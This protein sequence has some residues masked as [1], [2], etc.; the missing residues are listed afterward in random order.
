MSD[1][2]GSAEFELRAT[3]DKMK[4]DLQAAEKDLKQFGNKAEANIGGSAGRIG[5]GIGR[6]AAVAVAAITALV[7]VIG[8]AVVGAFNLGMAGQ[9]MASDIANS[10]KQIGV[11]TDALQEWRSVA[12]Q[13]G[14]A[15]EDADKA[16]SAF[17]KKF[18]EA[19]SGLSKESAKAFAAIG[20]S[21]EQLRSF[22][23]VEAALDATVDRIGDLG[24]AADRAAISERL[25]LGPLSD[26]L[27]RGADDIARMR[28]EAHALGV[29]MDRDMIQRATEAQKEF[30]TLSRIIGIQLQT[31]F[32][33][34]APVLNTAIGLIAEAARQ[35]GLFVD[36]FRELENR[37]TN[38]LQS[39]RARL[40]AERD[41]IAG[42]FGTQPLDGRTVVSA[43]LPGVEYDRANLSRQA[44]REAP[45]LPR[46][47]TRP[48]GNVFLPAGQHFDA[49]G[50]RI[51]EID[52]LL[53]SRST[54]NAPPINRGGG[55]TL[56]LP[57]ERTRVDRSAEREARR[58][59]RVEQE[60]YRA[61]Q[62]LLQ[63]AEGDLLTARDRYDLARDQ[64]SMDRE[65]RDAEIASKEARGEYKAVE[66]DRLKL[67]NE[68]ADALEDRIM[69]DNSIRD[70]RE[71]E[72]ANARIL[73][74]LTGNLISI[75]IG[76][77]RTAAER[78]R[79]ELELLAIVQKQRR[80]ALDAQLNATPGLTDADRQAAWD[81][82]RRVEVAE[83]GAVMRANMG[84]LDQWRDESLRTAAEVSEAFENIAARGLDS[85]NDGIVDAI[86]NSKS[87]GEVFSNVARQ[88]LADLLKISVRRGIT[89]PLAAALFGG[90]QGG[91]GGGSGGGWMSAAFNAIG[92]AFGG[93][94]AGG[95]P[96]TG[97]N[98]YRVGEHGPENIYMP[99]DGHVFPNGGMAG[100]AGGTAQRQPV[101][102]LIVDEGGLFQAR[103]E[104]I[105]G[106]IAVETGGAAFSGAR[107][108]VPADMAKANRYSLSRPR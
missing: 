56:T 7:A 19:A 21:R 64:L 66:A 104:G 87:L 18:A 45:R 90:G 103:V 68:E 105:A 44:Q 50:A 29:V 101:V 61:R 99:K 67:A 77:A 32:I 42:A 20:I 2:V 3:R 33:D 41:A 57:P 24:S 30:D 100:G 84:P 40:V 10:A 86:M 1:V 22:D 81:Q 89:E 79:L 97:G 23:T 14:A 12:Q 88:I 70:I 25:G 76:A 28:D 83:R 48:G 78:E 49:A 92:S 54:T 9:K 27:V 8:L 13:T 62:R 39:E 17:A 94:R 16:L 69:I 72:L 37:T 108:Q 38:G 43:P 91:K 106:P 71:E 107:N 63:V 98:W 73:S 82:N 31:A 53:A 35:L 55:S 74:D 6:M 47:E 102:K 51:A 26:A 75:Q 95:G 52:S 15:A 65:A 36:R 59:E 80:D 96:M 11:G 93:G 60:I 85:L 46:R 5:A 4:G 34:L 58:A